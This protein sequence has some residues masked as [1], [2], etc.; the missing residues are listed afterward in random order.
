MNAEMFPQLRRDP[1]VNRWALIA[2]ERAARPGAIIE[3]A[4]L[5]NHES[6]CPFCEGRE[7]L[8]PPEIFALRDADSPPNYPGWRVRIVPNRFPAVRGS[9]G[10]H[11]LIVECPQHEA[12]FARFSADHAADVLRAVAR[13]FRELRETHASCYPLFFK[14]HGS[15]AGA[16]LA[17]AHSQIIAMCGVPPIV[18]EEIAAIRQHEKQHGRCLFCDLVAEEIAT[19][20]RVVR[21]SESIIAFTA[22]AGRF[23]YE[24][25]IMPRRH[26]ANVEAE[27]DDCL[28]EAAEILRFV[29]R[30][31]EQVAGGP[32][33]NLILHTGPWDGSPFHWHMELLPRITG[34]AGFEWGAGVFI[35]PL[36]PEVA[37]AKFRDEAY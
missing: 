4:A 2:P 9:L 21:Q 8:T 20:V 28:F 31:L 26:T 3:P 34:A 18:A 12:S 23:P 22:L 6:E 11:E 13:R 37:A 10:S 5:P 33:Y 25:W 36:P 24:T 14:N 19:G 29:L 16:S 30:R 17:H 7:S 1:I 15:A 27:S 35:N 32:A